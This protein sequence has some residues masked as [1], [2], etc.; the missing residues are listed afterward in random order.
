MADTAV[1]PSNLPPVSANVTIDSPSRVSLPELL[2]RLAAWLPLAALGFVPVQ[3]S[4]FS[5][6][7]TA[8]RNSNVRVAPAA[9]VPRLQC[10]W[11]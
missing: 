10:R 9:S 1:V 7:G 8:A 11:V 3:L 5:R 4:V 2:S 6:I